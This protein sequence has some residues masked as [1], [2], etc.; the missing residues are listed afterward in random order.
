MQYLVLAAA[1]VYKA[2][3]LYARISFRSHDGRIARHVEG[4]HCEDNL[5]HAPVECVHDL[6][7]NLPDWQTHGK[8]DVKLC[9]SNARLYML[10]QIRQTHLLSCFLLLLMKPALIID[11]QCCRLVGGSVI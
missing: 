3:R 2:V 9:V 10:R 1:Q 5:T 6:L 7:I 8:Q 4:G 11:I